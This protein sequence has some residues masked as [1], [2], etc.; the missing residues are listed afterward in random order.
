[1]IRRLAAALCALAL[2][3]L[4]GQTA[5]AGVAV[6]LSVKE[7]AGAARAR[8]WVTTGVPLAQGALSDAGKLRIVSEGRSLPAQFLVEAKWPDGS[9]KWVLCTFPVTVAAG[10]EVKVTLADAGEAPPAGRLKVE[11]GAE[12]VVVDTG[13]IKVR[14]GKKAFRVLDEVAREGKLLLKQGAE[15]GAVFSKTAADQFN[16][17]AAEPEELKVEESGPCRACVMARGWF[18]EAWKLAG[19]DAV[20]WTCRVYLYEGSDLV[21][22]FF[23]LGNDGAYMS[24]DYLKFKGLKLDFGITPGEAPKAVAAEAEGAPAGAEAF[25]IRQKGAYPAK[26]NIFEARLGEKV[27]AETKARSPGALGV[28]GAG[29][30]LAVAV[31]DF[32]QNYPKEL[33]VTDKKLSLALWPAWAGYP[34]G[35]DLYNLCG[36]MQK[37]HEL[38]LRFGAGDKDSAVAL[39]AALDRPLAALASPEYYADCGAFTLLS[40][41]GVA[42]GEAELDGLIKRYDDLQRSKPAG[43]TGAAEAQCFGPYYGWMNWGDLYWACGSC[44]LHYDWTHINLTHWLRTGQRDFFDWGSAMA[45]HQMDIDVHRSARDM[46]AYRYLCNY[47]KET[48]DEG[49]TGWHVAPRG[50]FEP[51]TSHDWIQGQCQYAALTGDREAWAAA[52][53]NAEGIRNRLF[54]WDKLDQEKSKSQARCFGWGMECLL[55]LYNYTGEQQYLDDAR[56]VFENGLYYMFEDGKKTGDLGGEVQTGYIVRPIIDYHWHTGDDR[57]I[58]M[59]KAIVDKCDV[60]RTRYEYFMFEDPAAYVYYRTGEEAYLQKARE[61]LKH[62][63]TVRGRFA[64]GNGAWTKEEAK[65]SRTGYIHIAIERLKKQGKAP[66]KK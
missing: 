63:L 8:E 46:T 60:W 66:A 26:A 33:A 18:P 17:A 7:P 19:K 20:R 57:A 21:R 5:F 1:M 39:A 54:K 59:L 65:T 22:V 53:A 49:Q 56:K 37:T 30:A 29:G 38:G 6:E 62:M 15:D 16:A 48:L 9:V 35:Q 27:L 10:G 13:V 14:I 3:A 64:F 28:Q 31:R 55:A 58:E 24:R 12:A 23:T 25:A 50:R 47:E 36:G 11:D 2:P 4:A 44:T 43:L 41:A 40:P 34:E 45:R 51:I 52:R 42:T 32:W 61:L